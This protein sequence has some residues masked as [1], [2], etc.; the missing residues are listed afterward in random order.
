MSQMTAVSRSSSLDLIDSMIASVAPA[1]EVAWLTVASVGS[2]PA[3]RRVF[4]LLESRFVSLGSSGFASSDGRSPIFETSK[5][6][7][8]VAVATST[9]A[10][11]SGGSIAASSGAVSNSTAST[12]WSTMFSGST[13]INPG[14]SV[15]GN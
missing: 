12:L 15:S 10:A 9:G 7:G 11:G 6:F 14:S 13:V 4:S 2:G 1:T 3:S 8:S 5:T